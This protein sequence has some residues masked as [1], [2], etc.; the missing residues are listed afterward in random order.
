MGGEARNQILFAVF[1]PVNGVFPDSGSAA[2]TFFNHM[3]PAEAQRFLHYTG[4]PLLAAISF[5]ASRGES[6]GIRI[7]V[8]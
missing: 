3:V 2:Q 1:M 4:P 5:T 8:T 7:A 6:T